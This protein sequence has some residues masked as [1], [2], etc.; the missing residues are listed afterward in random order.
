VVGQIFKPE[1]YGIALGSG[2]VLRESVNRQLL[3]LINSGKYQQMYDRWFGS[4]SER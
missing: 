3:E 2:S 1:F 4:S